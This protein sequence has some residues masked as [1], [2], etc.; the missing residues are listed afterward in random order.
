MRPWND[1]A[2][3]NSMRVRL[4]IAN[5]FEEAV[6]P[7]GGIARARLESLYDRLR[8]IQREIAVKREAGALP[9][10]DL[11]KQDV[12]AILACVEQNRTKFET[13]VVLGIG[14]SALGNTACHTALRHPYHNSLPADRR[15][16]M[17]I[18]VAD[19]IDPDRI[20]GL[21]DTLD[22]PRTVFNVITKSGST[23]ETASTFLA[24]KKLLQDHPRIGPGWREHV[25]VTTD[26]VAGDLR[27]FASRE[28]LVSFDIPRGVGGR[29]SVL[30]PV[31]LLSAAMSGIDI[32]ELLAGAADA[33]EY[34]A[35][36][37]AEKCPAFA[38]AAL[39]YLMYNHPRAPKRLAVMMP[40]S[41]ALKD[42]TDWFRQ[43]WAESLGKEKALDGTIVNVGPTPIKALGVTDQHSQVQLYIEGPNDKLFTFVETETFQND[44]VLPFDND[45]ADLGAFNYFAGKTL[46]QLLHAEQKATTLALTR[47]HRP[48]L[49]ISMKEVRPYT[50]GQ[51]FMLL[52]IQT[53]VAGALFGINPFDQPGVEAGKIATY[54]LMDR[55]G[56][57]NE[58]NAIEQEI[59]TG[60]EWVL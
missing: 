60:A 25:I 15:G 23:A 18:E 16:G 30:T 20:A 11:P 21:F 29:F 54:A 17:R 13:F 45:L 14:G 55:P 35:S 19:N 9:F 12:S 33:A 49:T 43:L 4:A 28:G 2:W 24:V 44:L 1:T 38:G 51:L 58:K 42:V 31:G 10:L 46:G 41:H 56:Y 3:K 8:A 36:V 39:H 48:N 50:V 52:E 6:G 40:Y 34:H 5:V 27:K 53:V 57:E 37:P 59:S 26:P 47:R 32:E 22:L 7:E